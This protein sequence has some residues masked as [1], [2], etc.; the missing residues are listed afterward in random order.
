M[1]KKGQ[2]N[3]VVIKVYS[4]PTPTLKRKSFDDRFTHKRGE[5]K[6]KERRGDWFPI[7][8]RLMR[9]QC[10]T[11]LV[12]HIG[13]WGKLCE[14]T[15]KGRRHGLKLDYIARATSDRN[16][17]GLARQCRLSS[18]RSHTWKK[19]NI[20]LPIYLI[21]SY[22]QPSFVLGVCTLFCRQIQQWQENKKKKE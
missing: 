3:R 14:S 2:T 9:Q 19:K 10:L 4:D 5:K 18:V 16:S 12:I 21:D 1:K 8:S 20:L 15:W 11:W 22:F 13:G 17:F 7:Q 6:R